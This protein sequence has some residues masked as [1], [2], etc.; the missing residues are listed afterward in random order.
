MKPLE[1]VFVVFLY[2]VDIQPEERIRRQYVLKNHIKK[3][4]KRW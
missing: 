4:L 1:W 2:F 3:P